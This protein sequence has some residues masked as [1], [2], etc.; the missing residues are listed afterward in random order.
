MNWPL[1]RKTA[2]D[3]ALEEIAQRLE[4]TGRYESLELNVAYNIDGLVGEM[5]IKAITLDGNLEYWEYKQSYNAKAVRRA[6]D[7]GFRAIEAF[8]DLYQKIDCMLITPERCR[9]L[10]SYSEGRTPHPVQFSHPKA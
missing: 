10:I 6:Y 2:E 9:R 1:P 8:K 5:D 3:P 4:V 7:Q